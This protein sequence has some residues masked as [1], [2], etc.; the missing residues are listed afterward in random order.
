MVEAGKTKYPIFPIGLL[1]K[2]KYKSKKTIHQ[3]FPIDSMFFTKK[4]LNYW[5]P[6]I[7]IFIES[8][9]WPNMIINIKK[10]TATITTALRFKFS[11]RDTVG[12]KNKQHLS[13]GALQGALS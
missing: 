2:D 1:L 4:F 9:I 3:F 13:E 6:S 10:P 11:A 7:A 12:R 8:E 5:K